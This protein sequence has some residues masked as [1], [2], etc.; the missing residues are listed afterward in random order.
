MNQ[1]SLFFFCIF[2]I[3]PLL[4]QASPRGWSPPDSPPP[5]N[6]IE[7]ENRVPIPMRDGVILYADV[8]RPALEGKF[9]V[10]VSRTPCSSVVGVEGSLSSNLR[11]AAIRS[12]GMED[13]KNG[14]RETRSSVLPSFA[15]RIAISSSMMEIGVPS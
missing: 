10:L 3:T 2:W 13:A 8:Y 1:G 4:S 15:S 5:K 14:A 9:P 6:D 7:L 11:I 12:P